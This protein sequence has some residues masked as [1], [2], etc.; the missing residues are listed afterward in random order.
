MHTTTNVIF[1]CKAMYKHRNMTKFIHMN[2]LV[3]WNLMSPFSTNMAISKIKV[4]GGE[5]SLPSEGRPVI[6]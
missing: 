4:R 2:K 1:V 3:S 6:Y 5:L